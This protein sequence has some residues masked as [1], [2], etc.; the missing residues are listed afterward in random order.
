MKRLIPVV[1]TYDYLQKANFDETK[2]PREHG[3]FAPKGEG[4]AGGEAGGRN[5]EPKR[6]HLGGGGTMTTLPEPPDAPDH[7]PAV[8]G[9]GKLGG[10]NNPIFT[11]KVGGRNVSIEH[12]HKAYDQE[13][14]TYGY[15]GPKTVTAHY[16]EQRGYKVT[17]GDL[18]RDTLD[19]NGGRSSWLRTKTFDNKKDAW[20]YAEAHLNHGTAS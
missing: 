13:N 6:M 5:R 2:H 1:Y 14:T 11:R 17:L 8:T 18:S 4:E 15:S 9:Y 20:D 12:P 10:K 3:R 19:E 7:A 16:P